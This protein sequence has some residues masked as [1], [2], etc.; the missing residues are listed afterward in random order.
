MR[1]QYSSRDLHSGVRG[2]HYASY[3]RGTNLVLLQPDI[4]AAFPTER[5]VNDALRGLLEVARTAAGQAASPRST[6]R[7]GRKT[8]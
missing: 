4:A 1:K 6:G 2:K 5:A 8:G 7:G 3:T